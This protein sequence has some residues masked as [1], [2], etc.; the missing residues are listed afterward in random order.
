M[1]TE[2][3]TVTLTDDDVGQRLDKALSVQLDQFSRARLQ[4]LMQEGM[5]SDST[6]T[7]FDN[8]ALKLK[9]PVTLTITIPEAVEAKP[10]AEDI[11]LDIVFEDEHLLV[12]NKPAGMV[13]HP[14]AGNYSGTLVNALLYH[15]GDR[16]SGI[17]GVKR[18]GIV[19]R[20]DKETSGLMVVAKSD[21]AHNGLAAQFADRSLSRQYT[22]LIWGA[23][24]P[25]EGQIDA[26]IGRHP[27]DRKKMT[28]VDT[29]GKHAI[30]H[31]ET[32]ERFGLAASL[33]ECRLE[34]GRTHQIRVHMTSIGHP[35][36]G[37][38]T[39][40][41]TRQSRRLRQNLPE[42]IRSKIPTERQALHAWKIKFTH[43]LTKETQE[44]TSALPD[45]LT[46]LID[47]LRTI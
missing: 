23:I 44:Y 15:C 38:A 16:L 32:I 22:A 26:A 12:I 37:D 21:Q 36:L 31:Y 20:L 17:G 24:S 11:P 27:H 28:V 39:Y 41:E 4:G 9:Q 34:T 6:G 40:G 46:L 29:G 7:V 18:P 3:V 43:P 25:R 35:L 1:M 14:A 10:V 42:E 13:V 47:A 45:D 8:P 19:H 5:V 33:I 30:T 2:H